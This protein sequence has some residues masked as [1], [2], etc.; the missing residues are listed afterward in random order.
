MVD[1]NINIDIVCTGSSI[2]YDICY[3]YFFNVLILN[4]LFLC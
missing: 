2:L 4:D 3:V 1:C